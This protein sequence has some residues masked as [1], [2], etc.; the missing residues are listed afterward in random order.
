VGGTL[1]HRRSTVPVV[2]GV[3]VAVVVAVAAVAYDRWRCPSQAELERARSPMEVAEAFA[4]RGI[5]LVSATLPRAVVRDDPAYRGATTYRH[6]TERAA[7]FVLVCNT[8]CA[9]APAGLRG[10]PVEVAAGQR[11]Q[12]VRRFSTLGNNIA[13]FMTDNDRRSSR[14]LQVRVQPVLNNLDAAVPVDSHCYVE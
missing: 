9:N 6:V 13:I 7:L 5:A 14:K 3:V 1:N 4:D 2:A 12:H 11:P 10:S 8:R